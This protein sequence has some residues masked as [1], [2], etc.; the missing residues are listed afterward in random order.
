[1]RRLFAT[2]VSLV[3]AIVLVIA[4]RAADEVQQRASDRPTESA[5]LFDKLDANHD[6]QITSDEAP[7][8]HRRL[9]LR[10]VRRGDHNGDGK[11]SR[12]EFIA[13]MTEDRPATEAG[14]PQVAASKPPLQGSSSPTEQQRRIEA[15]PTADS[16]R[17]AGGRGGLGG[18]GG[19]GPMMGIAIFRVLDT[20]GDGKLDATEIAT[21]SEALKKLANKDGDV[22]RDELARSLHASGAVGA[23]GPQALEPD[24]EAVLKR[25]LQQFDKNSNGKLE[26]DELPPRLQQR[27]E[28]LD[29]NHDGKLDET[30]LAVVPR[31]MRRM[32]EQGPGGPSSSE[33]PLRPNTSGDDN[34][35]SA[36]KK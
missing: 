5:V 17:P 2:G 11:L 30:E 13:G 23:L 15:R 3:T 31:L 19:P 36:E 32:Q 24:P 9:F 20:N 29:T 1:M 7:E 25:M 8:E 18:A 4:A 6:G 14:R 28:E 35:S 10:L 27:F 22:T 34:K 16:Q 26:K 21:A 33:R 12:E